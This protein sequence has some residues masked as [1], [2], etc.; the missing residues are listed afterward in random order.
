M[1][2][3]LKIY[4]FS[5]AYLNH[6]SPYLKTSTLA[7]FLTYGSWSWQ[8]ILRASLCLPLPSVAASCFLRSTAGVTMLLTLSNRGTPARCTQT[9]HYHVDCLPRAGSS[10]CFWGVDADRGGHGVSLAAIGGVGSGRKSSG[11]TPLGERRHHPKLERL[12][13]RCFGAQ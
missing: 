5:T 7:F 12:L 10:C 9:L 11:R 3:L 6:N 2:Y 13:D 8:E 4:S 1:V